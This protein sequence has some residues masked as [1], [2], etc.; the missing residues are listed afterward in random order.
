MKRKL[1]EETKQKISLALTKKRPIIPHV[2]E[3]FV[4]DL[5]EADAHLQ[6]A[7]AKLKTA[8][9][10]QNIR[11]RKLI[12]QGYINSVEGIRNNPGLLDLSSYIA[13]QSEILKNRLAFK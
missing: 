13:D 4:R 12:V 9:A 5:Q 3:A 8:Q 2:H 1:S 6:L 10:S 11:S 7:Q